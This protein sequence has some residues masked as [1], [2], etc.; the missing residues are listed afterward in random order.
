MRLV[1][2]LILGAALGGSI[3]EIKHHKEV[4]AKK[5]K[6]ISLLK[7]RI[8]NERNEKELLEKRLGSKFSEERLIALL[9]EA[10]VKF[11]HI[12]LAQARIETGNY[13]SNLFLKNKNL[14]GMC[15][16]T[17]RSTT[18]LS[19]TGPAKFLRWEDSVY[20]YAIWQTQFVSRVKTDV[21]YI[22]RLAKYAKE[23]TYRKKVYVA[24]REL[25]EIFK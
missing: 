25:I 18:S 1:I 21:E 24:S 20:D 10:K 12:V 6:H 15:R 22:A 4:Q 16:P 9:K 13:K 11:P 14:F 19:K 3:A 8:V 2:I 17:W 5:D 7:Q 23:K